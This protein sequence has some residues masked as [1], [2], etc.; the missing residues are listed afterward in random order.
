[1]KKLTGIRLTDNDFTTLSDIG[2]SGVLTAEDI[3][4][5]HFS[6][7]TYDGCLKRLRQYRDHGWTR[8]TKLG[9]WFAD[10]RSGNRGG[11]IPSVHS[12][13]DEGADLIE[14]HLGVRPLRVL[15]SE[16][17]PQTLLHRLTIAKTMRQFSRGCESV[18]LRKPA[19]ILEQDSWREAPT[20]LPPNQKRMLYH[21][22]RIQGQSI[23]CL[24][25]AACRFQIKN[26]ELGVFWEIDRSTEGLKQ[27]RES[28]LDAYVHL[29]NEKSYHRYWSEFDSKLLYVFW[30]CRSP[31]RIDSLCELIQ[32][33]PIAP[34]FRFVETRHLDEP[35]TLL[36]SPIWQTVEG[37]RR[38]IFQS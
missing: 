31:Q 5:T 2:E 9:V 14:S 29:L 20:N 23:S 7:Y 38:A 25:D 11:A 28:K 13:T 18:G 26:A 16:P 34:Y 27:I 8:I 21:L 36:T 35:T 24:P 3:H 17:A 6:E 12:L 10:Q 15:R 19:W 22:F 1:M 33:H 30:V 37:D 32:E 4:Q